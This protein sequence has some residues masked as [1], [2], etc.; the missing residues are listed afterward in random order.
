MKESRMSKTINRS[1]PETSRAGVRVQLDG[2]HRLYRDVAAL[3]S[4]SLEASPG[5]LVVLL[6][7]SGCGK[8]TALRALAGLERLDG[9]RI[10]IDGVDVTHVASAKRNV[11]MV[12]Q[13]YSLFPNMTARTNVEFG[14]RVRK[15]SQAD[16]KTRSGELLELMGL[17]EQADRFPHQLSGGQQQRVALARALAIK[18]E[19]LLL[20][21][22]LSALDAKVRSQLRDEIR[23]IQL[24]LGITTFFVTH[25]QEEALAL[26][27]RIAVMRA[28]QLEQ[29][30]SPTEVYASPATEFVAEF[31][32]S[33]NRLRA[34]VSDKNTLVVEAIGVVALPEAS[35]GA[36]KGDLVDVLVRPE[37]IGITPDETSLHRVVARSFLG[38]I[39]KVTALLD[40]GRTVIAELS[41]LEASNVE[42]DSRVS[43]FSKGP[44]LLVTGPGR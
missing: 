20:D 26:A 29:F 22:P 44:A 42:V 6:G 40:S 33:V 8:T 36:I 38:S 32:G 28:G 27:D 43:F 39:V 16:Q 11:G 2:L 41:L 4:L 21:E 3:K 23:R 37:T 12:F 18:P 25:D 15:A 31:V 9:G 5:E 14:L 17:T 7:P 35:S 1:E 30:G 10:L 19:V 34:T 24:E 13:S